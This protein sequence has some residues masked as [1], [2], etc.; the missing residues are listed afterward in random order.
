MVKTKA[1]IISLTIAVILVQ[2][3]NA[4]KCMSLMVIYSMWENAISYTAFH[5]VHA[6]RSYSI[7][8]EK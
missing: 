5:S 3:Q 6:T 2:S 7:A 1:H 4:H 8:G